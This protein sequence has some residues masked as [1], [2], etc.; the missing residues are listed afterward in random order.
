MEDIVDLQLQKSR[1]ACEG[2]VSALG[3]YCTG[4]E[5]WEER[6]DV[7]QVFYGNSGV[8]AGLC[9]I[10]QPV[11]FSR[12]NLPPFDCRSSNIPSSDEIVV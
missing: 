10:G 7:A 6:E 2:L 1:S 5:Q 3:R 12:A 11:S 9:L 4:E 8:S